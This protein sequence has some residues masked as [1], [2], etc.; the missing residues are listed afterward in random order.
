MSYARRDDP[1]HDSLAAKALRALHR[2]SG[3]CMR[4]G[5][6][7]EYVTIHS[8]RYTSSSGCFP[9]C[10]DCWQ[11]LGNPEARIEYYASLIKHW[12]TDSPVSDETKRAIQKAVANGG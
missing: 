6:P 9:L 5:M 12:E 1:T 2:G 7:W 10:E 4:C 8:T 3:W 11:L